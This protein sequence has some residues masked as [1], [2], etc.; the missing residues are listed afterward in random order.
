M[1][2]AGGYGTN[3]SKQQYESMLRDKYNITIIFQVPR[4]PYIHIIDLG[5]CTAIQAVLK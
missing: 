2:N 5:V 1:D 3:D 4:Y